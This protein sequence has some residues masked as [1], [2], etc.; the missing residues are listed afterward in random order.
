MNNKKVCHWL[1]YLTCDYRNLSDEVTKNLTVNPGLLTQS[2]WHILNHKRTKSATYPMHW[3]NYD[4]SYLNWK[5]VRQNNIIILDYG[6]LIN[7]HSK[8]SRRI[9]IN[10]ATNF[11]RKV[12]NI[13]DS[14]FRFKNEH[15]VRRILKMNDFPN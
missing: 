4:I 3:T 2:W 13:S 14:K 10:T 12:F 11:I 8:H 7:Y 6:R 9:K 1:A 5:V 15:H